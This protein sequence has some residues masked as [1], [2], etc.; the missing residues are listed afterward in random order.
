MKVA[1]YVFWSRLGFIMISGRMFD[2]EESARAHCND[3][4]NYQDHSKCEFLR[5][6]GGT[7]YEVEV[8]VPNETP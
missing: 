1:P 5:W 2:S 7:P 4:R 8:E 6:L 3:L